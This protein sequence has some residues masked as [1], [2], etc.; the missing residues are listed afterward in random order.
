MIFGTFVPCP[1]HIMLKPSPEGEGTPNPRIRTLEHL[2]THP[3]TI[4]ASMKNLPHDLRGLHKVRISDWR[5]FYWVDHQKKKV[6]PYD[7]AWRDKAYKNL[8][9]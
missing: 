5:V 3:E 6:V 1:E 8:L 9:G 7:I 2:A 4:G